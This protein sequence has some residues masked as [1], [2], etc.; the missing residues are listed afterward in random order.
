MNDQNMIPAGYMA[1]EIFTTADKS[2]SPD[3]K[4]VYSVS[5][6]LSRNFVWNKPVFKHNGYYFF[7]TPEIIRDI[8]GEYDIDL[9]EAT[10]FYYEVYH[11]QYNYDKAR[12]ESFAPDESFETNVMLPKQKKL[13]G[14]DVA[15]F[16]LEQG[17]EHSYLSC[18]Y[19]AS[20]IKT[21]EHCLLEDFTETLTY[22]ENEHFN[23]CEPG[24]SRIFSVYTV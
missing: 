13:E 22:V 9:S 1:K 18:N 17:P 19:M 4:D 3:V 21:N 10:L 14:Y 7:D 24:P 23:Y 6:C 8:A 16:Y 2:I 20:R 5:G 11:K 15:S 12:W